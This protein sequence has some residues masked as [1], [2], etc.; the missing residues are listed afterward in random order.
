MPGR[1]P[2]SVPIIFIA[3]VV[4]TLAN[5][6]TAKPDSDLDRFDQIAPNGVVEVDPGIAAAWNRMNAACAQNDWDGWMT[7]W[8]SDGVLQTRAANQQGNAAKS[9]FAGGLA[10]KGEQRCFNRSTAVRPVG[11]RIEEQGIAQVIQRTANGERGETVTYRYTILW[12]TGGDGAL[13]VRQFTTKG[14]PA[15]P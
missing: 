4:L 9:A 6:V 2:P 11:D 15:S 1:T 5:F 12:E 14:L 3:S 7:T 10:G 13:V 8:A